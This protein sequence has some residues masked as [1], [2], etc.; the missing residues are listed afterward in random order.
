[1]GKK[2]HTEGPWKACKAHED[3]DGPLWDIDPE[4]QMEYDS[5]PITHIEGP[6]GMCIANAHDLFEFKE[7]DAFLI[8]AA[9]DLLEFAEIIDEE[10]HLAHD[11]LKAGD[12]DKVFNFLCDWQD[13][14]RQL[15]HKVERKPCSN[16][17]TS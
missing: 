8:E 1:M 12:R 17:T 7:A 9:P 5:K 13:K 6:N 10:W 3:Y 16:T 11:A 4:D 15:I 2:K 14:A